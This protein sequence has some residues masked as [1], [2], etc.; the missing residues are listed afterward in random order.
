MSQV[1]SRV[2]RQILANQY[3]IL[4]AIDADGAEELL[5]LSEI[6]EEGY[7]EL[8]GNVLTV[9]GVE[10]DRD[11]AEETNDILSMLGCYGS[12]YASLGESE[13]DGIASVEDLWEGF[14]EH[15]TAAHCAYAK[16]LMRGGQS[17][18]ELYAKVAEA[19]S[20]RSLHKYRRM[21]AEWLPLSKNYDLTAAQLRKISD[22]AAAS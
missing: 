3:R 12:A 4:A 11:I 10:F 17:R 14:D 1:L 20:D 18:P 13:R 15:E 22:A 5:R 21:L 8:Y 7:T 2:E 6:L 16:F 9:S 19:V